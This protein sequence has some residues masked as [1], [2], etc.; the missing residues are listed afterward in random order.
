MTVCLQVSFFLLLFFFFSCSF[1]SP[2]LSLFL[3]T[4]HVSQTGSN[5]PTTASLW[6][7]IW[8]NDDYEE[9]DDNFD[10]HMSSKDAI[11]FLVDCGKPMFEKMVSGGKDCGDT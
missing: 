5:Q 2:S 11:V 4:S 9:K 6:D 3:G 7:S 10:G 1:S 8:Q